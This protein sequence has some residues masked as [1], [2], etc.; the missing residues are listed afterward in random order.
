MSKRL[1]LAAAVSLAW[2]VS[3]HAEK[4][5]T[6]WVAPPA[7]Y[8]HPYDGELELRRMSPKEIGISCPAAAHS[9][10]GAALACA[11]VFTGSCSIYMAPDADIRKFGLTPE[12]VLRHELAHCNG[13][14][15]DHRGARYWQ[16]DWAEKPVETK[17]CGLAIQKPC[18]PEPDLSTWLADPRIWEEAIQR[19]VPL[20]NPDPRKTRKADDL[21]R[22]L[23][24]R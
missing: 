14:P 3:A 4:P 17:P 22:L 24:G 6:W 15:G 1:L 23:F 8:D 21:D 2:V 10:I 7:E 19:F 9:K 5:K 11:F 16:K 20:P 13:W 12:I 18:E